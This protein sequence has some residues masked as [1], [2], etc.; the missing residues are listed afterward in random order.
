MSVIALPKATANLNDLVRIPAVRQLGLLVLLAVAI[1]LGLWLFFW[2]QKPDFVPVQAGLDAKSTAEASELL[3]SARIP[4]KIDPASGALAVP[5]D[6]VAEARM[7]LAAAGLRAARP[8][9]RR[10]G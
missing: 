7:A 5:L 6:Q 8:E 9:E 2:S 3:R 10:V 4:F 1:A